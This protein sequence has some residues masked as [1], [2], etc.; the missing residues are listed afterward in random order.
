MKSQIESGSAPWHRKLSI[1]RQDRHSTGVRILTVAF[2]SG[3]NDSASDFE[4]AVEFRFQTPPARSKTSYFDL[5]FVRVDVPAAFKD[6]A[7]EHELVIA[8]HS[9]ASLRLPTLPVA[10][11][12]AVPENWEF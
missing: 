7:S 1:A 4:D 10:V 12:R 9:S 3:K 11:S 5:S 8:R 6:E 2:S